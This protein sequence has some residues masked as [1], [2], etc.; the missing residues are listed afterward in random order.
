MDISK[1]IPEAKLDTSQ[2]IDIFNDVQTMSYLN[3]IHYHH[4][5]IKFLGLPKVREDVRDIKIDELFVLPRF[6][7][8]RIDPE[9]VSKGNVNTVSLQEMLSSD[10][11]LVILGDPGSGKSTLVSWISECLAHPLENAVKKSLGPR[12]P[13]PII[14]RDLDLS[15]VDHWDSL[16]EAWLKRPEAVGIDMAFLGKILESGQA[17]V[18]LDGIDEISDLKVRERIRSAVW[19]GMSRFAKTGFLMTSRIIGYEDVSF[20]RNLKTIDRK[21]EETREEILQTTLANRLYLAPFDNNQRSKF[22]RNWFL[23]QEANKTLALDKANEMVSRLGNHYGIQ[24]I[25]RIPNLLTLITLLYRYENDLPSGRGELFA[26]ISETYLDSIDRYRK[27][28]S[29]NPFRWRDKERWL[30]YIAFQMQQMRMKESSE[31]RAAIV[32]ER[33]QIME[34][35]QECM[36][37]GAGFR[38]EEAEDFLQQ[39]GRRSGLFVPRG[40]GR[41]AFPHLSFQEFYAALYI[42]QIMMRFQWILNNMDE[43]LKNQDTELSVTILKKY[44][45]QTVWHETFVFLFEKLS[46]IPDHAVELLKQVFD[47]SSLYKYSAILLAEIVTDSEISIPDVFRREIIKKLWEISLKTRASI[48]SLITVFG[49]NEQI[50]IVLSRQVRWSDV[51]LEIMSDL[52]LD[53]CLNL[54]ECGMMDIKPLAGLTN[55]EYLYLRNTS[56]T[57]LKPLAGL[58][59][60]K[61]LDLNFT[62][63]SD[64][65]PLAGLTN[66]KHLDLRNT[67]VTDLKPLARLTNLEYLYLR[68]TSVTDLKPL[69]HLTNLEIVH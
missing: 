32:V 2:F 8:N 3:K 40:E 53:R 19:D 7:K 49:E 56:V 6:S 27:L 33:N 13:M 25:S 41:Y 54:S 15:G 58:M 67:S 23:S 24:D 47:M 64:L 38:K 63:V 52:I 29:P 17:I 46:E 35:L 11:R 50:G 44:A 14:L 34:W 4:G 57:D 30:A 68:N 65:K 10:Q 51:S 66:L 59:N 60:L 5:Y 12:I 9:S 26:K 62:S 21:A 16:A 37:T 48:S 22:I 43:K 55:L 20:D 69:D 1:K 31:N 28:K 39:T 18:L 36:D 45:S 61:H 42:F